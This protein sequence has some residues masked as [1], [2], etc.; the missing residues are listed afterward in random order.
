MID[1]YNAF[2]SYR[3]S[4]LDMKI[5]SNIQ[6]KLE[7]FHIPHKIRSK[8]GHKRIQ[9]IFR[10]KDELPITSSLN[11][12]ISNALDKAD[13]LIV[14]C[15]THTNESMWVKREIAY[16]LE[17]HTRD[18]IL[19][20]LCD[21]EP[22]QVIPEELLFEERE[23]VGT[24]GEKHNIRVPLEPLS[25]D[26]RIPMREADKIELPRLAAALIGCSYDELMRRR[27]QYRIRRLSIIFAAALAASLAFG[28]YMIVTNKKINDSLNEAMYRK[29]LYLANE[30]DRLNDEHE[31]LEAI[32]VALASL[33]NE[34]NSKLPVTAQSIKALTDA[35]Y[36]YKPLK[37]TTDLVPLWNYS[38]PGNI[39]KMEVSDD[40]KYLAASD[41]SSNFVLWKTE[42]HS[43]VYEADIA[44]QNFCFTE[45]SKTLIVI[46]TDNVTALSV[47]NGD[48]KWVF[49]PDDGTTI[50]GQYYSLCDKEIFVKST[51][52][53]YSI[54]LKDGDSKVIDIE[55]GLGIGSEV[56]VSPNGKKVIFESLFSENG[57]HLM[58]ATVGSSDDYLQSEDG[59]S[60]VNQ[61][62]W[63]DNDRFV[64]MTCGDGYYGG[65]SSIKTVR[66]R[67]ASLTCYNAADM[68]VAW[69]T[70]MMFNSMDYDQTG[71]LLLPSR[72]AV[73]FFSGDTIGIFDKNNGQVL[74][75]ILC[76]D[77][78]LTI[79]DRSDSG[80]P[81][82]ITSNGNL[83]F[84]N[85]DDEG[86]YSLVIDGLTS[87]IQCA[88]IAKGVYIHRL[89]GHDIIYYATSVCDENF[90]QVGKDYSSSPKMFTTFDDDKYMALLSE[91]DGSCISFIDL[92]NGK[93]KDCIY[94]DTLDYCVGDMGEIN[95]DFYYV[96]R[97]DYDLVIYKL[98]DDKFVE[99]E[100]VTNELASNFYPVIDSD[101]IW[102]YYKDLEGVSLCYYDAEKDKTKSF[103]VAER[104]VFVYSEPFPV[105]DGKYVVASL[106]G[107]MGL[108][109]V[110][111]EKEI[112]LRELESMEK[113]ITS[114]YVDDLVAVTDGNRVLI[115]TP[116]EKETVTISCEGQF[117]NGLF[118]VDKDNLIV[119][120]GVGKV[121][122][123]NTATGELKQVAEIKGEDSNVVT[124]GFD[125]IDNYLCLKGGSS[126]N[127]IDMESFY[128]I[129]DVECG[130]C[131]HKGSDSFY[132][133]S[134][135]NEKEF[136]VGYYKRYSL[137]EL[138]SRA[139][140][141]LGTEELSTEKKSIYGI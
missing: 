50:S 131:Y 86:S 55:G 31:R 113:I 34:E 48:E 138:I 96:G 4:P 53:L 35:T 2:I 75:T 57:Y 41:D 123:Y 134:H 132:S 6:H 77:K 39:M 90:K 91:R 105:V 44:P 66:E 87:D 71:S 102:Y 63:L 70:T 23:V 139:K 28:A 78:V 8:T 16:F 140:E 129:A 84:T 7:H 112:K 72:D 30:S 69:K 46:G 118:F 59:Y 98:K 92:E 120:F 14:I 10:D 29:A 32:Q 37:G 33:P 108:F 67:E 85:S 88:R 97:E 111:K 117:A 110:E 45:D 103:N 122:K 13:Y 100:R 20:V 74:S 56:W 15:S 18:R 93:E 24:D 83:G 36:A 11:D 119:S 68:S 124:K 136:K 26:Y 81:T 89:G 115:F 12:T 3:H 101:K 135:E 73:A 106:D 62:I 116:G 51:F 82:Y 58:C 64:V 121:G 99:K 60:I 128:C 133:F 65:N 47:K 80:N 27:R 21:G 17:H 19:T 125:L 61:C 49:F 9:R 40:G 109:D 130:L 43:K 104:D 114:A 52:D 79:E 54:D 22:D 42:D 137:E 141:I 25:C 38:M 5:A 95:G 127:V 126:I 94:I 107:K 1:H 76:C